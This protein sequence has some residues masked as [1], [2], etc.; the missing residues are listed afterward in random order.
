MSNSEFHK[1][2]RA[3]IIRDSLR[4][5]LEYEGLSQTQS[6]SFADD[7]LKEFYKQ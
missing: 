6:E 4:S 1:L 3:L 2:S 5:L 7:W